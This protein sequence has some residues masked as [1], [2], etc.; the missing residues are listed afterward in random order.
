MDDNEQSALLVTVA[1]QC[2]N[3]EKENA[4][5]YTTFIGNLPKILYMEPVV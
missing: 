4:H 5:I 1:S 2:V 3:V